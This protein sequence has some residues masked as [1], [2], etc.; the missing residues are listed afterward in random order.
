MA[1]RAVEKACPEQGITLRPMNAIP[2][3]REKVLNIIDPDADFRMGAIKDFRRQFVA[4]SLY[5]LH[6]R[7][8]HMLTLAGGE[9][10]L[11]TFSWPDGRAVYGV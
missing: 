10:K 9:D 4:H 7:S 11:G 6:H 5:L 8:D 1:N 3:A 2:G